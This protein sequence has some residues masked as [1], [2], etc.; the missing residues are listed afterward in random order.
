MEPAC[1]GSREEEEAEG[2]AWNAR[3]GCTCGWVVLVRAG[4]G[5]CMIRELGERGWTERSTQRL[6]LRSNER[7]SI[8][9]RSSSR[10]AW[11]DQQRPY[12]MHHAWLCCLAVMLAPSARNRGEV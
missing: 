10:G 3:G 5:T 12:A 4:G 11:L 6:P 1:P 9:D 2:L 7:K 8:D